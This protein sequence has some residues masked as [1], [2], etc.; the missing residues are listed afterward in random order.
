M[1]TCG[2]SRK[3]VM[4]CT[5][6]SQVHFNNCKYSQKFLVYNLDRE[7]KSEGPAAKIIFTIYKECVCTFYDGIPERDTMFCT[8]LGIHGNELCMGETIL[9]V[10]QELGHLTFSGEAHLTVSVGFERVRIDHTFVVYHP[11][12]LGL[13]YRFD[14]VLFGIMHNVVGLYHIDLADSRLQEVLYVVDDILSKNSIIE[15]LKAFPVEGDPSHFT[16]LLAVV[17]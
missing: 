17:C 4:H 1:F 7:L 9:Q 16:L 13:Q 6:K 10:T 5:R 11:V 12:L 8:A 15:L 2:V 14:G 3:G